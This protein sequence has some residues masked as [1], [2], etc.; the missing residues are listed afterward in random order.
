MIRIDETT[1]PTT[2]YGTA[3]SSSE[4]IQSKSFSRELADI[5]QA[6]VTRISLSGL[7]T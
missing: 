4:G 6:A 5:T 2:L 3:E 7:V 1:T